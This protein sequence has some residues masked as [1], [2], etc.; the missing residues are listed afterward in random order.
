MGLD[1]EA[2]LPRWYI[3]ISI[4]RL[5]KEKRRRCDEN[6]PFKFLSVGSHV[7]GDKRFD[8]VDGQA[9]NNLRKRPYRR[10]NRDNEGGQRVS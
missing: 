3:F 9:G 10:T 5:A 6:G 8:Y 4:Y 2:K 7:W 1:P